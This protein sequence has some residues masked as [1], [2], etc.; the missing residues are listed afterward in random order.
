VLEEAKAAIEFVR[1]LPEDGLARLAAYLLAP[2][3]VFGLAVSG[4]YSASVGFDFGTPISVAELRTQMDSLGRV[5]Q[6]R[7]VALIVE[8]VEST[9]RIPLDGATTIWTSL[10][11]RAARMNNDLLTVSATEL[12]GRSP[13]IGVSTPVAVVVA[14]KSEGELWA[15]GTTQALGNLDLE[16]HRSIA[17]LS[18][19]LLVCIFTFGMSLSAILPFNNSIADTTAKKRAHPNQKKII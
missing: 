8:P 3:L 1:G 19:I 9:F 17:F 4:V 11:Q 2:G 12:R 7:G 14:G 5:T 13:F 10:D 16:P 6:K 15:P 18:N